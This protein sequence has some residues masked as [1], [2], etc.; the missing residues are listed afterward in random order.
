[1]FA[2]KSPQENEPP[3]I[4]YRTLPVSPSASISVI[5]EDFSAN[6]AFSNS[7]IP[8]SVFALTVVATKE[9]SVKSSS[10]KYERKTARSD[11][12]NNGVVLKARFRV[13]ASSLPLVTAMSSSITATAFSC[14]AILFKILSIRALFSPIS[15]FLFASPAS[16]SSR[17]NACIVAFCCNIIKF[18]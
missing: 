6:A 17:D 4:V 14:A 1:M 2:V 10:I 5:S 12:V 15:A 11:S 16:L 3:T 8:P 18:F 13:I 9:V 7:L